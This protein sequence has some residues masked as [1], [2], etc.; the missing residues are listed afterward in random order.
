M[1]EGWLRAGVSFELD[2][3][4][5]PLPYPRYVEFHKFV[6]AAVVVVTQKWPS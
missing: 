6:V 4:R 2:F 1:A 3:G 5:G